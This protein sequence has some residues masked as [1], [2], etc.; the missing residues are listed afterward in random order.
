MHSRI[1]TAVVAFSVI[2]FADCSGS[3]QSNLTPGNG[4]LGSSTS[5]A[6]S[7]HVLHRFAGG[8]DGAEPW[9]GLINVKGTLYGTTQLGG[10]SG[11]GTVY[12]IS[13]SGTEKVLYSF[14][15]SDGAYP[16][17]G[18]INVKGTLYGTTSGGGSSDDGTVYSIS[19]S[20]AEK[21]QHSFTGAPDGMYPDSG[22]IN[23]KGTLY[24]TTDQGGYSG[25]TPGNGCGTIFSISTSGAETVLYRFLGGSYG[26]NPDAGLLNVNG[27]LYGATGHGG[28]SGCEDL[29]CGTVFSIP[30]SGGEGA[31]NVLYRFAG[32]PDGADPLAGLINVNGTFYGTTNGGGMSNGGIVYSINAGG[33]ENVLHSFAGGSDGTE[34]WAGLINVNGT[35]Y[36]TTGGDNVSTL[37]TVYSISTSGQE[38]VL[39]NFA[40]GSDGADPLADLLYVKTKFYGTTY[41][42]GGSGCSGRGCGTVFALTP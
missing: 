2:A 34:P 3:P 13:K 10:S 33:G 27:T 9:A 22:L 37:G 4:S 21:V 40:G 23:V 6:S 19:T 17:S 12:S 24:G 28:T 41:A 39:H 5:S 38:K 42:G 14:G 7:Y 8:S 16:V 36:G 26:A 11:A 18:L 35:L 29:G 25:C 31:E 20:G 15:G 30:T 1:G 32:S